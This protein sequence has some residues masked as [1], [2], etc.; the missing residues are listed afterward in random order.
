MNTEPI[1]YAV[2][3]CFVG[4][5]NDDQPADIVWV[6]GWVQLIAIKR[7]P[8]FLD[9]WFKFR[10]KSTPWESLRQPNGGLQ[11]QSRLM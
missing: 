5:G 8:I 9:F 10:R 2:R 1:K 11:I 4:E 7:K 6:T 3:L